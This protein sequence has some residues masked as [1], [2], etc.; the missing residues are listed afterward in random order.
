MKEDSLLAFELRGLE[1]VF[2]ASIMFFCHADP[3]FITSSFSAFF[4]LHS[5]LLL[6]CKHLTLQYQVLKESVFEAYYAL[7]NP[8]Q[9]IT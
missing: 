4:Y 6:V 1:A 2:L 5:L 7:T 8:A 3:T 9:Q